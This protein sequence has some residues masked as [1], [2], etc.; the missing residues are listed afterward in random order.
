MTNDIA[1]ILL[2]TSV[3]EKEKHFIFKGTMFYVYVF[4]R[5]PNS[6][7]IGILF[8]F[9]AQLNFRTPPPPSYFS[10]SPDPGEQTRFHKSSLAVRHKF[11]FTVVHVFRYLSENKIVVIRLETSFV[12]AL[13]EKLSLK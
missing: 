3:F 2:N 1:I 12:T 13:K 4:F 10:G 11:G 9:W 7:K 5:V 6:P 8:R